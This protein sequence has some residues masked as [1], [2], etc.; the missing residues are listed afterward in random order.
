MEKYSKDDK[1]R[2]Y[3]SVNREAFLDFLERYL[4]WLDYRVLGFTSD[5]SDGQKLLNEAHEYIHEA[6]QNINKGLFISAAL[7]LLDSRN[8]TVE[9][10][11]NDAEECA[12]FASDI[13]KLCA[14]VQSAENF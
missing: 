8:K 4:Q 12:F 10:A 7:N 13:R 14:L 5:E 6:A 9:A 2:L 3:L 11:P 1:R